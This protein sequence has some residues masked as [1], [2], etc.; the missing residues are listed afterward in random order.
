MKLIVAGSRNYTDKRRVFDLLNRLHLNKSNLEIV[1][2][3]AAG[4]DT[5]GKQWAEVNDVPVHEFPADWKK[6]GKSAGYRRNE[7]MA[8]FADAL[9]AFWDGE[10]RGTMHMINLAKQYQLKVAVITPKK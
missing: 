10:S 9:L 3:L 6:Y 1:S 7:D 4:P 8:K 2:G 5:F